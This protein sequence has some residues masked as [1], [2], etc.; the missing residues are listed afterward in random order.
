[1]DILTIKPAAVAIAVLM[2]PVFACIGAAEPESSSPLASRP[3]TLVV[4]FAAGGGTDILARLVAKKLETSTRHTVIVDNKPGANGLI[5]SQFVARA[6]PDG[7]T[8]VLGSNSTHVIA[9]LL[10]P[11]KLA[12]ETTKNSFAIISVLASTP[13]VLAV[14]GKSEYEN[15]DQFLNAKPDG[16][17]TYGTFGAGSS[18]HLMGALLAARRGSRLLHVPYKG[19]SSAITDLLGR[20][21]DSVFLTVAAVGAYVDGGQIRPLAVTGTE[22]VQTLPGVPT[23]GERGIAGLENAG[24]F[25][26]FAPAKTPD[27]IVSYLRGKLRDAMSEPDMQAKLPELGLQRKSEASD[28]MAIWNGSVAGTLEILRQAKIHLDEK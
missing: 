15:L 2:L 12:M 24:W 25:A 3:I 1:M 8:L 21:I 6:T 7:H 10:S 4:P 13:L 22:R 5:A 11:D 19:S 26:V 17:L 28:D 18:A 27:N 23:F 20:N 9:P 16:G 14:S